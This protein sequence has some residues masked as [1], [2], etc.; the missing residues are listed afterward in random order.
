M[1][2]VDFGLAKRGAAAGGS[3]LGQKLSTPL[4]SRGAVLGTTGYMSPNRWK[5]GK[6]IPVPTS[7]ASVRSSMKCYREARLSA[8]IRLPR[9]SLPF[10]A[11]I[12]GHLTCHVQSACCDSWTDA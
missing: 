12:L 4:T 3:A 11:T 6:L 1:K 8:A 10:S 9:D 5:D 7:S 2:V